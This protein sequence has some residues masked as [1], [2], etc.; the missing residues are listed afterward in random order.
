MKEKEIMKIKVTKNI[1]YLE[2]KK[3]HEHKPEQ[4][5]SKIVQSAQPTKQE[6]KTIETQ[7]AENDFNITARA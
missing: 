6:S 3:I 4:T 5:F 1:T 2:A 7:F